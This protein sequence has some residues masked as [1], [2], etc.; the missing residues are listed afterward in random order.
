MKPLTIKERHYII[1]WTR[2]LNTEEDPEGKDI[3]LATG[4]FD[5]HGAEIYEGNMVRVTCD[6]E[7]NVDG[8]EFLIYWDTNLCGFWFWDRAL[9]GPLEL[10]YNLWS[11]NPVLEIAQRIKTDTPQG[12]AQTF[13]ELPGPQDN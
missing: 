4:R 1:F 12:S 7:P 13:G 3:R 11:V 6:G 2:H 8:K 10:T 9:P 5:Q